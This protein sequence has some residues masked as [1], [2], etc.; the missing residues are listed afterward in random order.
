M[1]NARTPPV[2]SVER[3]AAPVRGLPARGRDRRLDSLRSSAMCEDAPH[4]CLSSWLHDNGLPQM[5]ARHAR[6][7]RFAASARKG[8]GGRDAGLEVWVR[9]D[10][11]TARFV[12]ARPGRSHR[13]VL[14]AAGRFRERNRPH[15]PKTVP[16][17]EVLGAAGRFRVRDRPRAPKGAGTQPVLGAAGRFRFRDRPRAPKTGGLGTD[18]LE[19]AQNKAPP[20]RGLACREEPEARGRYWMRV[21][22]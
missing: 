1:K 18:R 3:Y 4:L 22:Q 17:I 19:P 15:A 13:G 8:T 21:R 14:G 6:G 10:G 11:F 20:E 9:P 7:N 16:M 12:R 2:G 5:G